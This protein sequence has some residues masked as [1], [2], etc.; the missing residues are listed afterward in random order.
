MSCFGLN[1]C[2]KTPTPPVG[3]A[4]EAAAAPARVI[5]YAA[6]PP[7]GLV[8]PAPPP[9]IASPTQPPAQPAVTPFPRPISGR[10]VQVIRSCQKPDAPQLNHAQWI[11][12]LEKIFQ[13]VERT[14]I[15]TLN[16]NN[17]Q[18]V[19]PVIGTP[20]DPYLLMTFFKIGDRVVGQGGS[21]TA[22]YCV[23][24]RTFQR[25]VV[26]ISSIENDDSQEY[27]MMKEFEKT[28]EIVQ[29]KF[30]L[31]IT[32]HTLCVTEDCSRGNLLDFIHG[33][34]IQ[35]KTLTPLKRVSLSL[36]LARGCAKMHQAGVVHRD[37]KPANLFVAESGGT[38][39]LKIGDFG[40]AC[41]SNQ[42]EELLFFTGTTGWHCRKLAQFCVGNSYQKLLAGDSA[43]QEE[44]LSIMTTQSDMD[45][46]GYI[47]YKLF[48][49]AFAELPHTKY[50]NREDSLRAIAELD[51]V[52]EFLLDQI[53]VK[54]R[55]ILK[56]IFFQNWDA[57]TLALHLGTLK[58]TLEREALAAAAAA[59][60]P[61]PPLPLAPLLAGNHPTNAPALQPLLGLLMAPP[62]PAAPAAAPAAV[63]DPRYPLGLT[64]MG[65]AC[66][67]QPGIV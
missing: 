63:H 34:R 28:R 19:R 36:D 17:H 27:L 61:I 41:K 9:A 51:K 62:Q 35:R 26:T 29:A 67:P 22:Y 66:G 44:M 48:H 54:Y 59:R 23:N 65:M 13:I 33:L 5:A 38:F 49:D 32:T 8:P 15:A 57:N 16:L 12:Q 2:T 43:A 10:L 47:L 37:L 6:A 21:K 24:L 31:L 64:P 18:I 7:V 25:N 3:P 52:L 39:Q 55:T 30:R 60:P 46:V 4:P 42:K 14:G 40:L 45:A 58:T 56:G 50:E 11:E 53:P 1:C 20:Q